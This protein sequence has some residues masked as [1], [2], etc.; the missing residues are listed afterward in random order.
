MRAIDSVMV[1]TYCEWELL[2]IDDG[3]TDGTKAILDNLHHPKVIV[4]RQEN[5]GVSAARNKGLSVSRGEFITFL[6]ADDI[7]PADS[8]RTRVEFALENENVDIVDGIISVRDET[9]ENEV[10]KYQPY[11]SGTILPRLLRLDDRVFFGVFYLFRRRAIDQ[12]RFEEGITHM[13]DLLFMLRLCC[14]GS[15][16]VSFINRVVYCY[17]KGSHSA[18]SNMRGIECGYTRLLEKTRTMTNVGRID[19]WLMKLIVAKTLF[20]SWRGSGSV[21]KGITA[22]YRALFVTGNNTVLR[23]YG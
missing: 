15:P 16:R 23:R 1:Q 7:L 21:R 12:V 3:S 8:L 19:W 20:L 10:R 17:R 6:D 2:I 22:A 18:M 14:K 11:Y 4:L 9:L 5:K 13:E